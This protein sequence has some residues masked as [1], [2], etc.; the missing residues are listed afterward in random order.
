MVEDEKIVHLMQ[1]YLESIFDIYLDNYL[2]K[3]LH[4][5]GRLYE[6]NIGL[7]VEQIRAIDALQEQEDTRKDSKKFSFKKLMD[8]KLDTRKQYNA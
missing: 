5:L 3:E 8:Y 7:V 1:T 2:N 6:E 4:S